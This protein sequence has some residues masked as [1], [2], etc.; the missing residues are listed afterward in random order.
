MHSTVWYRAD[1]Y[2]LVS[3]GFHLPAGPTSTRRPASATT[4]AEE[5]RRVGRCCEGAG[6]RLFP[7]PLLRVRG[8]G[9]DTDR[10]AV[11]RAFLRVGVAFVGCLRAAAWRRGVASPL[12]LAVLPRRL[13]RW[14]RRCPLHCIAP[15][16]ALTA[17]SSTLVEPPWR[18]KCGSPWLGTRVRARPTS[19]LSVPEGRDP[20][21]EIYDTS[22]S[23]SDAA[24]KNI[25]VGPT[26]ISGPARPFACSYH[27]CLQLTL[28][29]EPSRRRAD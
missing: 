16:S 15:A 6:T 27:Y 7:P 26:A 25:S 11:L 12:L 21:R 22:E 1:G 29:M 5:G 4:P 20:L 9:G 10:V 14:Q 18:V 24:V 8:A 23:R 28:L 19:P 13:Q 2:R 17:A 3:D